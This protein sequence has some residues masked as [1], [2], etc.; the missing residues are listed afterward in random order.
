MYV[1]RTLRLRIM[2]LAEQ[3]FLATSNIGDT[4]WS[5]VGGTVEIAVLEERID[6]S[7][8]TA[9]KREGEQ[10]PEDSCRIGGKVENCNL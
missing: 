4:N 6:I 9:R 7:L 8:E 5:T 1:L 10:E 3:S 2:R